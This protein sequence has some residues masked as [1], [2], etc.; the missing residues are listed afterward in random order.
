MK[1]RKKIK[2]TKRP[3]KQTMRKRR[4][5]RT[6]RT[7]RKNH[8][9]GIAWANWTPKAIWRGYQD[10]NDAAAEYERLN[11]RL[12]RAHR[13]QR[14]DEDQALRDYWSETAEKR[15]K[16][17]NPRLQRGAIFK[18]R[19]RAAYLEE[20]KKDRRLAD[21]WDKEQ[22]ATEAVKA[23]RAREMVEERAADDM[24]IG[25]Q[26]LGLNA[27]VRAAEMG[28]GAVAP[29]ISLVEQAQEDL[30]KARDDLADKDKEI[31]DAV[32][33]AMKEGMALTQARMAGD[34][35]RAR[36]L[37][38]KIQINDDKI[39]RL[40]TQRREKEDNL[41]KNDHIEKLMLH[42]DPTSSN[43]FN[44]YEGLA[45]FLTENNADLKSMMKDMKNLSLYS[46]G[47]ITCFY[48]VV[49]DDGANLRN[50]Q[51][52]REGEGKKCIDMM[53]NR[54]ENLEKGD[55]VFSFTEGS[56]RADDD[57]R[58]I[59]RGG[60]GV[61]IYV[62]SGNNIF[63]LACDVKLNGR[64]RGKG[65]LV[66]TVKL[67]TA[68]E[69]YE[70]FWGEAISEKAIDMAKRNTMV[71]QK[72]KNTNS[73]LSVFAVE[74]KEDDGRVGIFSQIMNYAVSIA[75]GDVPTVTN[76]SALGLAHHY[77]VTMEN[78]VNSSPPQLEGDQAFR[79]S[80]YVYD[81]LDGQR[82]D[83][84]SAAGRYEG[85]VSRNPGARIYLGATKSCCS[86]VDLALISPDELS[87]SA[88]D[89]KELLGCKPI[90][91]ISDTEPG[92]WSV[93]WD[94]L[95]RSGQEKLDLVGK[96]EGD[97]QREMTLQQYIDE[98][99]AD[100]IKIKEEIKEL[101]GKGAPKNS[102]EITQRLRQM[103]DCQWVIFSSTKDED[104][105]QAPR[106]MMRDYI[107][108]G[109]SVRGITMASYELIMNQFLRILGHEKELKFFPPKEG[110]LRNIQ[111]CL[112]ANPEEEH[113]REW[114]DLPPDC[115]VK[116]SQLQQN[117]GWRGRLKSWVKTAVGKL[118]LSLT[119]K[120]AKNLGF[121]L[122][123]SAVVVAL[124]TLFGI[125]SPVLAAP[126]AVAAAGA[127]A[128]AAMGSAAQRWTGP[129]G[130]SRRKRRKRTKKRQ[131]RKTR[132]TRRKTRKS[133][134]H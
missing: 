81:I 112:P 120:L 111:Y 58:K 64:P 119:V 13:G 132:K 6:R 130:G 83:S 62:I 3:M 14:S 85:I 96:M 57:G 98:A 28:S 69:I 123:K 31:H 82:A 131:R 66:D 2:R 42:F 27:E 74:D 92:K 9:G 22:E 68:K 17:A 26:L 25:Q 65:Y 128:V 134:R 94:V 30:Q 21:F 71:D 20:M 80:K 23:G 84:P 19:A 54:I 95:T 32:M 129:G 59:L 109:S 105:G 79:A 117:Q 46:K 44:Y 36:E 72:M 76:L 55:I 103:V 38:K 107:P 102:P 127:G 60:N 124:G 35:A 70:H 77:A 52:D 4:R 114:I 110:Y 88:K 49:A 126:M 29:D 50:P 8:R 133:R 5:R 61:P 12:S 113:E 56:V 116:L 97:D 99:N 40:S 1:Q 51:R 63:W 45:L 67:M 78:A 122:I 115:C 18:N 87:L 108:K 41:A 86:G 15:A 11:Q 34:E 100:I 118:V 7:N 104:T 39:K 101:I 91:L 33:T 43:L 10:R 89:Q 125:A 90:K 106:Q 121:K 73:N 47:E 53:Q 93:A 24:A 75:G 37:I 16:I 48:K